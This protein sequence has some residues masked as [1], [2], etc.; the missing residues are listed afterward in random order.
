MQ[1]DLRTIHKPVLLHRLPLLSNLCI[2]VR[3]RRECLEL[4]RPDPLSAST[5]PHL[6]CQRTS[7][8]AE[9][10]TN[11]RFQPLLILWLF[12]SRMLNCLSVQQRRMD[13]AKYLLLFLIGLSL[14]RAQI[15]P[16]VL[17][18]YIKNTWRFPWQYLHYTS[19]TAM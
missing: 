15:T 13:P 3:T 10:I 12:M 17:C 6:L 16:G 1:A 4:A 7:K 9:F 18:R 5:S 19:L 14:A 11:E 8:L 2:C